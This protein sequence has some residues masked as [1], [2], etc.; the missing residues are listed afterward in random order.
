MFDFLLLDRP[1]LIFRP[2]HQDYV[3][4]SRRLFDAKLEVPP[5]PVATT[6]QALIELVRRPAESAA[7]RNARR[8]LLDTLHD[9]REGGS[10][11]RL[12]AVLAEE[13]DAA[14]PVSAEAA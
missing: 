1:V 5:G 3:T 8:A 13:L 6:A 10:A 11:D 14:Q 9:H 4:R 7:S 2:D 12:L